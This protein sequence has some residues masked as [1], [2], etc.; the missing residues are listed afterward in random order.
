[1]TT[2]QNCE[3]DFLFLQRAAVVVHCQH[4]DTPDG[5]T[6]GCYANVTFAGQTRA[7]ATGDEARYD[8]ELRAVNDSIVR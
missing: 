5:R 1:M 3:F 7:E 4:S 2:K 6:K 8:L